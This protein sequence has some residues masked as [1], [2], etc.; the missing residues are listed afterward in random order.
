MYQKREINLQLVISACEEFLHKN[1]LD[2]WRFGKYL[3]HVEMELVAIRGENSCDDSDRLGQYE[4]KINKLKQKQNEF[5][6][7][8]EYEN[9]KLGLEERENRKNVLDNLSSTNFQN[10]SFSTSS[11]SASNKF[12]SG[13]NLEKQTGISNQ[14][15]KYKNPRAELLTSNLI[16]DDSDAEMNVR[17]EEQIETLLSGAKSMNAMSRRTRDAIR[18]DMKTLEKTDIGVDEN[19][20]AIN[21]HND[22]LDEINRSSTICGT[23]TT[24]LFIFVIFI[25]MVVFIRLF[26]NVHLK[27]RLAF[28]NGGI[29]EEDVYSDGTVKN[30]L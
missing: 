5:K 18:D 26:P 22:L 6:N 13:S 11:F 16:D 2:N 1:E 23:L 9:Q 28:G 19:T 17:E 21:K 8:K 20:T 10:D 12:K 4:R 7:L 15:N 29:V 27:K 25:M 3:K 30:E 14:I 24:V